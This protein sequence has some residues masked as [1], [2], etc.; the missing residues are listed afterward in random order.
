MKLKSDFTLRNI[1]DD[2]I[3]IPTGEN[4]LD[5][6]AVLSLNESGAFLWKQLQT[7]IDFDGL[8][9]ALM[10]EYDVDASQA[11]TDVKEFIDILK[12]HHLLCIE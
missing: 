8:C 9:K 1:A 6:G 4:C 10:S 7:D 5:F 3:V 11:D 12:A 2:F